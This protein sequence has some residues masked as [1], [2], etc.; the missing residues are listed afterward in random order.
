MRHPDFY[1]PEQVGIVYRPD[2]EAITN[3]AQVADVSPAIEDEERLLLLLIDA[4]VD[5]VHTD[6]SLSV[7]GAVDDT[8]RTVEWIYD[9]L[10]E[11]SRIA[12]SFDTHVP[13]QIF[14]PGWWVDAD[15]QHPA[16][17]TLIS[18]EDVDEG[19]WRPTVEEEWSR[20]YVHRLEEKSRKVLTIWPYHTML[21]TIG[22]TMT[23]T[24]YEA[25]IYHA[26]ARNTAPEFLIKGMIPKTEHYSILEPEV[27]VP[28]YPLGTLNE[29]F[30]RMVGE[31]DRVYIAG[32]AKSHCVLETTA[33]L[34][35]YYSARRP[36]II[37]NWRVLMDC[38][39]SV[40]HPEVD[41][42]A[43]AE[44]AY[45]RFKEEY[46]LRLVTSKDPVE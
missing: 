15:G 43:M 31:Y 4:Q 41:F 7:P 25:V 26:A 6:G 2:V 21:G 5:F 34:I 10:P 33:S 38:T 20:Y 18:A 19:R 28:E 44:R 45:Q 11:I 13:M 30:V 27:K 32:Q 24:L 35:D 46:G 9:H 22:H 1:H 37:A 14:Y 40:Q 42:E 16:A 8:R 17:Y 23:P 12:A 36:D 3:A 39:S 29:A